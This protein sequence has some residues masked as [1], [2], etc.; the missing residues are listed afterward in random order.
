MDM[1]AREAL[2]LLGKS[3]RDSGAIIASVCDWDEPHKGQAHIDGAAEH[4]I[5][6]GT[7]IQQFKA[8]P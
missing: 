6:T 1:Y 3:L 2:K 8:L 7:L 4:A 5:A